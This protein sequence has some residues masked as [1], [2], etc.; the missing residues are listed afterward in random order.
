MTKTTKRELG[1]LT[2]VLLCAAASCGTDTDDG[3]NGSSD[4]DADG[5]S[6]GDADTDADADLDGDADTDADTDADADADTDADGDGDA[7]TDADSDGDTDADSDGDADTD[8]DADADADS[9]ADGDGDA[10]TDADGDSDTDLDFVECEEWILETVSTTITK[11]A[12][13]KNFALCSTDAV[14]DKHFNKAASIVHGMIGHRQ[15][16]FD[17]LEYMGHALLLMA[18]DEVVSE[19]DCYSA[20][21]DLD[22]TYGLGGTASVPVSSIQVL[23]FG[24]ENGSGVYREDIL[25]HEFAHGIQNCGLNNTNFNSRLESAYSNAQSSGLWEGTYAITNSQEYWAEMTQ[26][27]FGV[28]FDGIDSNHN[29]IN[30][31]AETEAYDPTGYTLADDIYGQ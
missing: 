30:G 17:Q 14:E 9:D 12:Y 26:S 8:S 1:W 10:D 3:G 16:I 6:D 13:M 15:D 11:C 28:N 19:F 23:N 27:Y 21:P 5:D 25:N 2:V 20:W 4:G 7:D 31:A 24:W 29:G 22:W 18:P